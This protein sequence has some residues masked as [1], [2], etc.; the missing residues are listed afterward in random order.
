MKA[1]DAII[2]VAFF[3]R[4]F[5]L[6]M[7]ISNGLIV[8]LMAYE[9]YIIVCKPFEFQQILSARRRKIIYSTFGVFLTFFFC[10]F[11]ADYSLPLFL[12]I[13]SSKSETK[14][15]NLCDYINIKNINKEIK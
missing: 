8:A 3:L 5:I 1:K 14:N 10:L 4:Q 13:M 12:V 6:L 15:R 7:D 11:A 2:D 9:R